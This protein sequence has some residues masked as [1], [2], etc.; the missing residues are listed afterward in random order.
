M[1]EETVVDV[2][3]LALIN[4]NDWFFK[5]LEA[6]LVFALLFVLLLGFV[7]ELVVDSVKVEDE[8]D[9]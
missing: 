9:A 7:H 6:W 3:D 4:E 2:L 5:V 1:C 8:H